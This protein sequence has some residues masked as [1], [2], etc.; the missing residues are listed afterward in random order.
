[1]NCVPDKAVAALAL[2]QAP[3][4]APNYVLLHGWGSN[5]Q[6]MG[7]LAAELGGDC[8]VTALDLPG[9]GAGGEQEFPVDPR[10]LIDWLRRRIPAGA[11]L[12]GWSLGGAIA[13]LFA[14]ACPGHLR[15]VVT[16]ATNPRFLRATDWPYAMDPVEFAAFRAAFVRERA[17]GFA[18]FAALQ[19]R[20]DQK[21]REVLRQ[22]RSSAAQNARSEDLLRALD[23]LATLDLRTVL[24]ELDLPVLHILG[25]HDALVPCAVGDECLRLQLHA[26][27]WL[28]QG[29]SHAPFLA[30]AKAVGARIL[31]FVHDRGEHDKARQRNKADVARSFGR[32]APGYEAAA[33]LQRMSGEALLDMLPAN[34]PATVLDIGSGTGYFACALG[35]RYPAASIIGLDIAEPM[36]RAARAHHG[37]R[38]QGLCADAEQ[39]PLA[40]ASVDVIFSN[41]A[42]QWCEDLPGAMREISRVLAGDG[43]AAICTLGADTL[44]ELRAAWRAVDRSVHVNRFA[45]TRA[46]ADA[47]TGAGLEVV[48]LRH[49]NHLM[50]Y[51]DVREL[52]R[53]LRQLG[54]HNLNR[55]RRGGL[56]GRTAWERLHHAYQPFAGPADI[57]ATYQLVW[58][59]L[60]KAHD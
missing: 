47:A 7:T 28:A 5:A 13:L 50:R 39:L 51:P 31:E 41:L 40:N 19:A 45:T 36:V 27:V 16:I 18:R 56:S 14:H 49:C 15:A 33:H 17:T 8:R 42:L 10:A 21:P 48:V 4:P 30:R 46:I 25:E 22:L 44:W 53:E 11:V 24:A 29:V 1:M 60:K 2:H 43:R 58:M 34:A 54:A 55:G 9:F 3:A 59:E 35:G 23:L 57:P 12:V 32:A 52:A 37:G 26:S 38:L 6:V 20:G